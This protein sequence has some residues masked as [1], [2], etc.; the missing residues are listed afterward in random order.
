M[1]SYFLHMYNDS[2]AICHEVYEVL[3]LLHRYFV[4]IHVQW[5]INLVIKVSILESVVG[6]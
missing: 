4:N 6:Q 1:F 3:E 5:T 2:Y